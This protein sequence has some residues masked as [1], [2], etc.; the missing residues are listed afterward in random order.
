MFVRG[1]PACRLSDTIKQEAWRKKMSTIAQ[2]YELSDE[3]LMEVYHVLLKEAGAP[4]HYINN[5]IPAYKTNE[6][7][8]ESLI[9][10]DPYGLAK[11]LGIEIDLLNPKL[12]D[13]EGLSHLADQRVFYKLFTDIVVN[14]NYKRTLTLEQRATEF[15]R[16][17]N[18]SGLVWGGRMS[19]QE[20]FLQ[21]YSKIGAD[22]PFLVMKGLLKFGPLF[23][24]QHYTDRSQ[25][26]EKRPDAY[27]EKMKGFYLNELAKSKLAA[28]SSKLVD[29]N[30]VSPIYFI[31]KFHRF[32]ARQGLAIS[33]HVGD[34]S[35]YKL[36]SASRQVLEK[37]FISAKGKDWTSFEKAVAS[38]E[39]KLVN[40]VP[41]YTAGKEIL[42]QIRKTLSKTSWAAL[43]PTQSA[44]DE[45]VSNKSM[46]RDVV[47]NL[48]L[49]SELSYFYDLSHQLNRH[50][51]ENQRKFSELWLE[52]F[53]GKDLCPITEWLPEDIKKR[54]DAVKKNMA[55]FLLKQYEKFNQ[56]VTLSIDVSPSLS[57]ESKS[58]FVSH[59][60]RFEGI[61]PDVNDSAFIKAFSFKIMWFSKENFEKWSGPLS[62]QQVKQLNMAFLDNVAKFCLVDQLHL[63]TEYMRREDAFNRF[64][65]K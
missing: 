43:S 17:L 40:R 22:D 38:L 9:G 46:R 35:L 63:T 21:T 8:W 57:N 3:Q 62:A 54:L 2:Y 20:T 56:H 23:F 51:P 52:C 64:S 29:E 42:S 60:S 4:F 14:E 28:Y 27:T 48:S 16:V 65:P 19:F 44:K 26:A 53:E 11:V 25:V 39:F 30:P 49:S 32:C 13:L 41:S 45:S 34:S 50:S 10:K 1:C 61:I 36:E 24:K 33:T 31:E 59:F 37:A 47:S 55:P 5:K 12:T 15:N 6:G 58:A 18:E 7:K